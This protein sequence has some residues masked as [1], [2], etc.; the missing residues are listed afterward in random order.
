MT[1]YARQVKEAPLALTFADVSLVP[2]RSRINSRADVST[3][4]RFSRSIELAT[5]IVAANMDTVTMAPMAIE[6]ARL[7]GIG[8]I[9][10]FLTVAEQV[11]EIEKVKRHLNVT[12]ETPYC[13]TASQSFEEAVAFADRYGVSS[14]P[15]LAVGE[16][17]KLAGLLTARDL[18]GGAAGDT[19]E[20]LMTPLGS[21]V[22]GYPGIALD[23]ARKDMLA[24]QVEKLPLVDD[25][26]QLAGLI[27]LKDIDLLERYPNATRDSQG[28]LRVAAA[29]GVRGG[30][31]ERAA[32]LVEAGCDALV[33]DIAHGH[34]EHALKAIE[35]VKELCPGTDLVAG[36]VATATG[37]GD[38]ILAGADA[39]KTGIGP[40]AA[41]STR[42][43]AGVGVPQ[44]TA[45]GRCADAARSRDIPVISDGGIREPGDVA[46]AIGNGASTVMIGSLFAGCDEAPGEIV[47]KQGKRY[48]I[49]RG[50][51]STPAAAARLA[52]EGRGDALDQYVAEG[53]QMEF[54]LK[55]PVARVV[56]QLVG[57][58]RSG[59]AY[60]DSAS[61]EEFWAKAEFVRQTEAGR[62]ESK[63]LNMA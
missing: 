58:L 26:G 28:R 52:I 18:R 46:K 10:R 25:Q 44:W 2:L 61:I 59:M 39:V 60:S 53:E 36:N 9:H 32:A 14:F 20:D 12:V 57:G 23:E 13:L 49:Y 33:L 63:P 4:S 22:V 38:L 5:P 56:N 45:V 6:M 43:V 37:T 19:V 54:E 35:K 27:T 16:E 47:V 51:A 21:L 42:I 48:K 30:Y 62:R 50:M 8:V 1:L 11:R 17:R 41:C 3:R 15:V 31:L 55:G 24:A 34:A 29:I 40:G 7:G